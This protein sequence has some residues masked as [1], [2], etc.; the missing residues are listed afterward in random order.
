MSISSPPTLGIKMQNSVT[1]LH[2]IITL[3][4]VYRR[5]NSDIKVVLK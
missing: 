1:N 5:Q 3:L 4:N 2:N